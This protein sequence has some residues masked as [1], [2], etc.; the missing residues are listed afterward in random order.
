MEK[1]RAKLF[2][3]AVLAV[4]LFCAAGGLKGQGI[5]ANAW[6]KPVSGYWEEP[7]WSLGSLPSTNQAILL[8]NAGWKAL[9]IG[10]STSQNYPGTLNVGSIFVS[11][12]P[13]SFNLLLLNYAGYQAPITANVLTLNS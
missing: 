2:F 5:Q 4:A 13:S 3:Y 1:A 10:P 7:Y 9:A 11:S 6:T 12:P 8:T